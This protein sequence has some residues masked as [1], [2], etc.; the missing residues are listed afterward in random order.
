MRVCAWLCLLLTACAVQQDE[1]PLCSF[2]ERG[3]IV[4]EMSVLL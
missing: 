2:D 3:R 4:T 1:P